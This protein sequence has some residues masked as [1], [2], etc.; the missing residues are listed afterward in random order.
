MAEQNKD[1][2]EQMAREAKERELEQER[3]R[4]RNAQTSECC[5][6]LPV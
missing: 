1:R 5:L 3:E 4:R 2:L 6:L